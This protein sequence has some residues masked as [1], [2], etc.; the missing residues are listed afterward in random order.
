MNN[1]KYFEDGVRSG[2]EQSP[3]VEYAFQDAV[4]AALTELL[5]SKGLYQNVTINEHF[6]SLLPIVKTHSYNYEFSYRPLYLF[7]RGDSETVSLRQACVTIFFSAGGGRSFYPPRLSRW[8]YD[9]F[10]L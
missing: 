8:I 1:S 3:D 9:S 5:E 4:R 6:S 10:V 7:S 2:R